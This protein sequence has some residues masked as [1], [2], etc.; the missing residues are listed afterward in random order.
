MNKFLI[1]KQA[2]DKKQNKTKDI[3]PESTSSSASSESSESLSASTSYSL[4]TQNL[5]ECNNFVL[6]SRVTRNRAK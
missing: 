3:S 4:T 6:P 5:S 1:D 2:A